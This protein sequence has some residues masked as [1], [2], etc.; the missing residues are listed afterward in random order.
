MRVVS[1]R[2]GLSAHVI[3]VWERRYKAVEPVRTETNRRLYSEADIKRLRLL[4]RATAVG[5]SIS[6]VANFTLEEL[7]DL[8]QTTEASLIAHPA[9]AGLGRKIGDTS[10]LQLCQK[11][12]RELD[13]RLLEAALLETQRQ[14]NPEQLLSEVVTPLLQWAGEQWAEGTIGVA[15]EHAISAVIR[16]FLANVRTSLAVPKG[17]PVILLTT[18]TGQSHEF[19]ALM[20]AVAAA[21]EG[22]QELYLGPNLPAADIA[23]AVSARKAAAVGLSI[24]H[25]PDDPHL[26]GELR[27]LRQLL[28]EDVAI[29]VGGSSAGAYADILDALDA[30]HITNLQ[31]FREQLRTLREMGHHTQ[32]TPSPN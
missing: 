20:A 12:A 7:E 10:H 24:I 27:L 13:M 28:P 21:S 29:L 2:T 15:Q 3:R 23:Q 17:G 26:G 14:L 1:K 25:P 30:W 31:E 6:A 32:R 9:A 22:W 8:L 11:A 19:G 18:P 5:H 16:P 4:H